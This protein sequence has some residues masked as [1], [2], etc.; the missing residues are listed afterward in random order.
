ML[1]SFHWREIFASMNKAYP[2]FAIPP[3]GYEGE[4]A[5]PSKF[6]HTRRDSL[7]IKLRSLYDTI[8]DSVA[9]LKDRDLLD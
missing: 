4:E 9:A 2:A 3:P 1:K 6:D 7:G 5:K 8:A